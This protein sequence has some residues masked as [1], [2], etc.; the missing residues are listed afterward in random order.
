MV[1]ILVENCQLP[2]AAPLR[3]K[4]NSSEGPIFPQQAILGS[5]I[6]T[7]L[8]VFNAS[9]HFFKFFPVQSVRLSTRVFPVLNGGDTAPYKPRKPTLAK[10]GP[11][12]SR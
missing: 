4:Q 12:P 10:T 7:R 8:I 11:L 1:M 3:P 6:G 9:E 2:R 5:G